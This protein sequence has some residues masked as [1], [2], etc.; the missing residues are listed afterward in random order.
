LAPQ[1]SVGHLEEVQVTLRE[2]AQNALRTFPEG[3]SNEAAVARS[4]EKPAEK[5]APEIGALYKNFATGQ[6]YRVVSYA[7]GKVGIRGVKFLTRTN[8]G[9]EKF[10]KTYVKVADE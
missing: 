1:I 6:K 2:Y 5:E 8:V 9:V 10:L 3:F 4:D 7:N